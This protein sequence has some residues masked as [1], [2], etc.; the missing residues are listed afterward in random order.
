MAE[1]LVIGDMVKVGNRKSEAD[2]D[3]P[4]SKVKLIPDQF[5]ED[6]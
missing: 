5:G 3:M 1:V 4:S 6:D 2:A